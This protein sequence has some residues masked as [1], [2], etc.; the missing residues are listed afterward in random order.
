L[1]LKPGVAGIIKKKAGRRPVFRLAFIEGAKDEK[2]FETLG[3]FEHIAHSRNDV[4]RLLD[5]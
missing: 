5:G 3:A 4:C 2:E 1:G